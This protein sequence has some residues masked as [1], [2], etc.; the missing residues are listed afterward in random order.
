MATQRAGDYDYFAITAGPLT[1]ADRF[2]H[3]DTT[4][5]FDRFKLKI[6]G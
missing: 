3:R 2:A 5:N 1:L 4:R 6:F